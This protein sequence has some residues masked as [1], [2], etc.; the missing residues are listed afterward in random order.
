MCDTNAKGRPQTCKHVGRTRR[1]TSHARG[2]KT[3]KVACGVWRG[4]WLGQLEA[5]WCHL[6]YQRCV[7]AGKKGQTQ[8]TRS[9]TNT[10]VFRLND[11]RPIAFRAGQWR[12]SLACTHTHAPRIKE[13]S[14]G[15]RLSHLFDRPDGSPPYR[16]FGNVCFRSRKT[17]GN[18]P[19]GSVYKR[20][21]E[22]NVNIKPH[23]NAPLIICAEWLIKEF[24]EPWRWRGCRY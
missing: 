8:N 2:W 11:S 20:G 5:G 3:E 10:I 6:R 24:G 22:L 1:H 17:F 4:A 15:E 13:T 9:H 16:I 19:N 18:S 23:H 7:T 12:L 21:V 14:V